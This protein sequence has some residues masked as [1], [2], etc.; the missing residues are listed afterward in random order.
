MADP[1]SGRNF[2]LPGMETFKI[3][4]LPKSSDAQTSRRRSDP[5]SY[6]L[7][8][9]SARHLGAAIRGR[10]SGRHVSPQRLIA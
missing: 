5:C 9:P 10:I 3:P 6:A 4:P 2:G 7:L 1:Q 8:A